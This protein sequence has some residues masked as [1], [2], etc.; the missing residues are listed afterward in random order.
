MVTSGDLACVKLTP[1]VAVV[2]D[3]VAA[4]GAAWWVAVPP[5]F[6]ATTHQR[7]KPPE[8]APSACSASPL[9]RGDR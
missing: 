2:L 1:A 5:P 8:P 6:V 7:T 9:F 4:A 3:S